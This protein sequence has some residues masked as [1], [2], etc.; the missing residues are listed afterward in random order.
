MCVSVCVC[1]FFFAA[2]LPLPAAGPSSTLCSCKSLSNLS[3]TL[4]V[5][6]GGALVEPGP[7]VQKVA[8]QKVAKHSAAQPAKRVKRITADTHIMEQPETLNDLLEWPQ[9][10][11][12]MLPQQAK[13]ILQRNL[14]SGI[15]LVT[16]FSGIGMTEGMLEIFASSVEMKKELDLE[17]D[18]VKVSFIF[19]SE[20]NEVTRHMLMN[21]RAKPTHIFGDLCL[22][23]PADLVEEARVYQQNV[24]NKVSEL[25]R[26]HAHK[27]AAAASLDACAC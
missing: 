20:I 2:C 17:P 19:A 11:I 12:K 24:L 26:Q 23:W 5:D 1:L 8:K 3:E 18:D 4:E 14:S 16:H 6:C 9:T 21:N 15:R 7:T 22:R 13:H 10:Y 27:E 25:R